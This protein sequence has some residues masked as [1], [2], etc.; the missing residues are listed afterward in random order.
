MLREAILYLSGFQ[1]RTFYGRGY[2]VKDRIAMS[3]LVFR[4]Q[5]VMTH[6][7][8]VIKAQLRRN[9]VT[10]F[11]GD[12]RFKDAHT[13]EIQSEDGVQLRSGQRLRHPK[14]RAAQN[15][16]RQ[17]RLTHN[18]SFLSTLRGREMSAN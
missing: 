18:Q 8:E 13:I 5:A 1:Q 11:V 6:E 4:A 2:V 10:T 14:S 12:A 15:L 9:E 16:R 17:S 3:D 7:V